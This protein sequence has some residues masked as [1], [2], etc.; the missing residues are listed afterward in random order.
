MA[1]DE[2]FPPRPASTPTI[3]AFAST[4]PD[5]AGLL[6]V[7]YTERVAAERIAE[8]F[9][10]RVNP[11]RIELIEPA[12][13]LDESKVNLGLM[14]LT[15]PAQLRI[16]L[17]L[18]AIARVCET[19]GV[20]EL[21]VFGSVLRDDFDPARSDVDILVRFI[22]NDAGP[23]W[24]KYMDMEEELEALLGRKVDVVSWKAIEQSRN[25]YRRNHIL[26]HARRVYGQG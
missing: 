4:H 2:F 6:K 5:Y 20:S 24:G 23:F 19:F 13:R 11:Y 21:A 22:N 1:I 17:P 8:Q 10:S 3:Y 16:D 15:K 9:P 25:P 12:M 14:I 26:K 18:D 7:D